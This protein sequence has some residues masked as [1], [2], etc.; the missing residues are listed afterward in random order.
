[1]R[2]Q[3]NISFSAGWSIVSKDHIENRGNTLTT[4]P[5]VNG[6][7]TAGFKMGVA[8]FFSCKFGL[9]ASFSGQYFSNKATNMD[10]H[11]FA[12]PMTLGIRYRF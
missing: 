10:Y 1:L 9:A 2:W 4:K 11:L 8:Y 3:S 7:P 6:G 5:G 12:L